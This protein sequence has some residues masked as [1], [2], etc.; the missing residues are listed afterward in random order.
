MI[1]ILSITPLNTV[2]SN[3]QPLKLKY[4]FVPTPMLHMQFQKK[5]YIHMMNHKLIVFKNAAD[6]CL[7]F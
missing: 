4:I 5:S 3:P 7:G 2:Y 1:A 6:L